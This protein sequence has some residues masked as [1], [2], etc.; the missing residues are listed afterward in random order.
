MFHRDMTDLKFQS[1]LKAEITRWRFARRLAIA[2]NRCGRNDCGHDAGSIYQVWVAVH[3][4]FGLPRTRARTGFKSLVPE[5]HFFG[6]NLVA[7]GLYVT[8][9]VFAFAANRSGV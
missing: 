9:R 4:S 8:F 2:G 5:N 6:A 1:E 7:S 3:H